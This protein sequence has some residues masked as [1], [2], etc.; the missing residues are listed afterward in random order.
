MNEA[1]FSK[2]ARDT[3]ESKGFKYTYIAGQLGM[4]RQLLNAKLLGQSAWKLDE[5]M[6]LMRLL[7]LPANVLE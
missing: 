1:K 2:L 4:S 7:D 3:I 5:A 6:K